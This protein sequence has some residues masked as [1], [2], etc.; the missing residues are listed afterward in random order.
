MGGV[1]PQD[2]ERDQRD[3]RKSSAG[4]DRT[5]AHQ[6]IPLS[7]YRPSPREAAEDIL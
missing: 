2:E 4:H 5:I 1:A 7:V 6:G 3:G